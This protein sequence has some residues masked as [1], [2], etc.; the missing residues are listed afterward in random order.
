M[1][2]KRFSDAEK[3]K[4]EWFSNLSNDN[5]VVWI[6]LLDDCD[7]AGVWKKNLRLLNFNCNTNL[8]EEDLIT[9]FG[10]RLVRISDDKFLIKKFCEFQYGTDWLEKNS[11]PILSA[12]NIL[13][14]E[15]LLIENSNGKLTLSKLFDN[16]LDTL[17]KELD[18]SYLTTKD[19]DKDKEQDKEQEKDKDKEQV[20]EQEQVKNQVRKKDLD[21][22]PKEDKIEVFDSMFGKPSESERNLADLTLDMLVDNMG[23]Q[24]SSEWNTALENFKDFGGWDGIQHYSTYNIPNYKSHLWFV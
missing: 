18:N 24:S 13:I 22:L 23:N 7:N 12:K 8:T 20:K 11:K 10:S 6:Y 15:G 14:K 17:N 2:K 9:I 16:S 3:W 1:A 19:K 21:R 4:D 5:K